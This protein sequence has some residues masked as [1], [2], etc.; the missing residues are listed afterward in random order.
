MQSVLLL[1]E[2]PTGRTL[3]LSCPDRRQS[4]DCPGYLEEAPKGECSLIGSLRSNVLNGLCDSLSTSQLQDP[5]AG[6]G[7]MDH[8]HTNSIPIMVSSF[9]SFPWFS[10]D[11]CGYRSI[12]FRLMR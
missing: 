8:L 5:G 10:S 2:Y 12:W 6:M 4:L 9:S 1:M 3:V 11:R 7:L